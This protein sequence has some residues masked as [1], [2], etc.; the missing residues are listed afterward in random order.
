MEFRQATAK[1]DTAKET[2]KTFKS[3]LPT[4][5]TAYLCKHGWVLQDTVD[6]VAECSREGLKLFGDLECTDEEVAD[7]VEYKVL[8]A[9]CAEHLTH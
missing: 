5:A 8:L 3:V 4:D 1:T 7:N 6:L 2:L 9:S